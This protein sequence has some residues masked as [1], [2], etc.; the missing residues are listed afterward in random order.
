MNSPVTQPR[1][2]D[3]SDQILR[4]D[5]ALHELTLSDFQLDVTC[6][7][8]TLADYFEQYPQLPGVV[9]LKKGEFFGVLSRYDFLDYLLRPQGQELFLR[10]PLQVLHSYTRTQALVL[11]ADTAILT[12]APKSLRRPTAEQHNPIVVNDSGSYRLLSVHDLHVAYWQICGIETQVRYERSQAQMLQS[13]KMAALGRLVDGVAHEILDPIGFIWGNLTH[14]RQYSQDLLSLIEAYD[15]ALSVRPQAVEALRQDIEV[16]YLQ[17]DLPATLT[18]IQSGAERIKHLAASLQNFC[19]IDEVYPKPADLHGLIDSILLL[20][21]SR[22][23]TKIQVVCNYGKL[24]PVACYSGQLSQVFMN[25][26][27]NLIDGLLEQTI[28]RDLAAEFNRGRPDLNGLAPAAPEIK[29]STDIRAFPKLSNHP[30]EE[31]SRWISITIADNGPGLSAAVEQQIQQAF[32]VETRIFKETSLAM[33]YRIITAR[34]GGKF[35]VRSRTF[36][37]AEMRDSVGT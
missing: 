24:P 19:H 30:G 15:A 33:S 32:S 35:F 34:H 23:T 16:D 28:R 2:L 8:Q 7:G 21:K 25:I 27:S 11:P 3:A 5:S 37:D 13:Q 17:R 20:L 12:A 6:L 26:L 4:I 29:I 9:L 36:S 10:H 14:V 31:D 18:S 22:L 1:Q